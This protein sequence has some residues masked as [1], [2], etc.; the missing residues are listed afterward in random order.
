MLAICKLQSYPVLTL[1]FTPTYHLCV[2]KKATVG[3]LRN[4]TSTP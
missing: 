4:F 1:T 2:F 3:I